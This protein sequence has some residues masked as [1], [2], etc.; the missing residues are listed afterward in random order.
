MA[1]KSSLVPPSKWAGF[2]DLLVHLRSECART[3]FHLVPL[4]ERIYYELRSGFN[5]W[6]LAKLHAW[7]CY[8]VERLLAERAHHQEAPKPRIALNVEFNKRGTFI[9]SWSPVGSDGRDLDGSDFRAL[10][11]NPFVRDDNRLL[12]VDDLRS[13]TGKHLRIPIE[14]SPQVKEML[15]R[16]KAL[17]G[18]S[19]QE[20]PENKIIEGILLLATAD[21][22]ASLK[23]RLALN[24]TVTMI[25]DVY[26][27]W[28]ARGD[29]PEQ[30]LWWEIQNVAEHEKAEEIALLNRFEKE[31]QCSL[32]TFVEIAFAP[33]KKRPTGPTPMPHTKPE[34][35]AKTFKSEGYSKVT[36][37]IIRQYSA[38]IE[39]HRPDLL[40]KIP[41]DLRNVI[42]LKPRMP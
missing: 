22:L 24:F 11:Y 9:V 36:P 13:V 6:A 15:A 18:R 31:F 21:L 10:P 16:A 5:E 32:K 20:P 12:S 4:Y 41:P 37:K 27:A 38:L 35:N 28:V 19:Y 3:G 17:S 8:D 1:R 39:K 34:R 7:W 25:E 23:R 14:H 26:M 33:D 42:P 30:L 40:P 2:F 29:K